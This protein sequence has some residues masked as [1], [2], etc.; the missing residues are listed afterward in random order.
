M[1]IL[2]TLHW[3][4]SQS[5]FLVS[6]ETYDVNG[7]SKDER[8]KGGGGEDGFNEEHIATCGYSLLAM[9]CLLVVSGLVVLFALIG[10]AKVLSSDGMPLV[11]SNSVVIAAAC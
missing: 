9:I 2:A 7:L 1:A 4:L 10:G 3:L 8:P 5:I 11:E 6:I